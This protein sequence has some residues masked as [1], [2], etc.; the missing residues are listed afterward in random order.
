[1]DRQSE[2]GEGA[3]EERSDVPVPGVEEEG[4]DAPFPEGEG[5]PRGGA[6]LAR[7]K[8]EAGSQHGRPRRRPPG[9]RAEAIHMSEKYFNLKYEKLR[10]TSK[11]TRN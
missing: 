2:A 3:G 8:S 11:K 7:R 4:G 5:H 9:D 1:M 10:C 6:P